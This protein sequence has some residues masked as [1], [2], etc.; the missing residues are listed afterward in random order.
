MG[1]V[2][3]WTVPFLLIAICICLGCN[4]TGEKPPADAGMRPAIP[5][6]HQPDSPTTDQRI[7]VR[8]Y[9][10]PQSKVDVYVNGRPAASGVAG[11]DGTFS[12]SRVGLDP[13]QNRIT[14]V[15]TDWK[16]RTSGMGSRHAVKPRARVRAEV[17]V[18]LK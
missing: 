13:G 14:A 4:T 16:G 2:P 1:T 8:G 3:L 15:A 6:L 18:E 5:M 17:R 7:T 9:A 11:A 10:D 12:V